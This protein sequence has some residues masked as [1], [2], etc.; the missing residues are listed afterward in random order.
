[1]ISGFRYFTYLD[2]IDPLH[3]KYLNDSA[4][5]IYKDTIITGNKGTTTISFASNT[6]FDSTDTGG[7]TGKTAT[8]KKISNTVEDFLFGMVIGMIIV[9]ILT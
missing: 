8:N 7:H 2:A 6:D 4:E 9:L 1:M 3:L 5:A